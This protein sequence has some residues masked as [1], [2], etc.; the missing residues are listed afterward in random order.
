MGIV[1][2]YGSLGAYG[3]TGA[4]EH[5]L[6]GQTLRFASPSMQNDPNEAVPNVGRLL[7]R[8]MREAATKAY[9]QRASLNPTWVRMTEDEF[10]H[11]LY[12]HPA[13]GNANSIIA[14]RSAWQMSHAKF[15]RFGILSLTEAR[16]NLLLWAHY[17]SGESGATSGLC[18]G[19]DDATLTFQESEYAAAG[20][21][22]IQ[23]VTYSTARATFSADST[24]ER[25]AE[26]VLTKSAEWGYERELRCIRQLDEDGSA[27]YPRFEASD[28]REIIIGSNMPLESIQRCARLHAEKFSHAKLLLALPDPEHYKM[29]FYP[30]PGGKL[31]ESVLREPPNNVSALGL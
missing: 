16:D 27:T 5:F 28:V 12:S 1:Y 25:L 18:I 8:A 22:G 3:K 30:L 21:C 13:L 29:L 11:K 15:R 19:F 2:K 26:I 4:I 20:I 14:V 23:K 10:L 17:A 9:P 6:E 24:E 31:L 7:D